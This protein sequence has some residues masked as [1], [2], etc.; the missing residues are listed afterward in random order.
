MTQLPIPVHVGTE[1]P[2]S[3]DDIEARQREYGDQATP[4]LRQKRRPAV[5]S[6]SIDWEATGFEPRWVGFDAADCTVALEPSIFHG[7]GADEFDRFRQGAQSR[8]EI[9]VVISPIGSLEDNPRNALAQHDDSIYLGRFDSSISSRPLGKGARVRAAGGLG[10][11]DSLLALRMLSCNPAPQWRSL[12][13]NGMTPYEPY[14]DRV[15]RPAQ[16]TLVPIVETELGEAV[17]AAWESPDGVERRYVVPIETPWALLLQWLLEQALPEYV[18]GAMRRARRPLA[19]DQDLMTHRERSARTALTN[20]EV[21]YAA[22]RSDLERDLEDARQAA[23]VVR[24][25]LLYGTGRQLVDAVRSVL[26]SAG[27]TVVDLDEKLGGTSNADL[28]CTYGGRRRLVEVKS[29]SGH[30]PERAYQDLVRHLREWPTVQGSVPLEGG[31]LVLNHELRTFPLER[32]PRPYN[33]PEFLAAQVEPVITTMELFAAWR[34]EDLDAIRRLLFDPVAEP[35][36]RTPDD[37]IPSAAFAESS[38]P[39]AGRR[40]GFWRR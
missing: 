32:S 25:G 17:V 9:A 35:A 14:N 8:G 36:E 28:L 20:F 15:D 18:P 7:Q 4:W 19:S 21:E 24:E 10:D 33:R 38:A 23:S 11:A 39:D 1:P 29:A 22:R 16:G 5:A 6:P 26:E 31:A 30:A 40:R 27:I 3:W 13:L 37:G 34:E 2:G 12:S